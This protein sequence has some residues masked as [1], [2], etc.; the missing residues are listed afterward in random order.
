MTRA[1][2]CRCGQLHVV[3]WSEDAGIDGAYVYV[4]PDDGIFELDNEYR[5]P[6][7]RIVTDLE[8]DE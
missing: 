7:G 3:R 5:N 4:C 8:E 2:D 6:P 1:V